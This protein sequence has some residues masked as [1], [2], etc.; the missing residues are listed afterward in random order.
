MRYCYYF[1][2]KGIYAA[3]CGF[4]TKHIGQKWLYCPHCG[5]IIVREGKTYGSSKVPKN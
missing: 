5:Y 4:T 1:K 3:A 2:E